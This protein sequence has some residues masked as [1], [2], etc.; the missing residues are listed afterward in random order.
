MTVHLW[1]KSGEELKQGRNLKSGVDAGATEGA[2]Y[3]LAQPT[4]L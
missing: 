1:M 2:A 4:F 3:W